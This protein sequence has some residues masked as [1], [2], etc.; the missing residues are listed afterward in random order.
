MSESNTTLAR[1]TLLSEEEQS[2]LEW[3]Y[4][5]LRLLGFERDD[6]RVLAEGRAELALLRRLIADGCPHGLAFR[7][8]S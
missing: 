8:A 7:I 1:V 5:Q 2:V 4:S 6:A 3:R